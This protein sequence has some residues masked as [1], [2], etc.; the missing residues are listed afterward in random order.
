[1]AAPK[2]NKFWEQRSVH[3]R[4]PIF[5]TPEELW[6]AVCE[7][8]QWV[9]ENPLY[10]RKCFAYQ[11]VVY[12]ED[13]PKMR[14]MTITAMCLALEISHQGWREYCQKKDF[15]EVTERIENII[16]TQKFEGAAADLLNA[17]I[18]ARDLGLK[19]N[20][21]IQHTSPDGSMTPKDINPALVSALVDKLIN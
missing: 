3:G 7:Y 17:N 10:E 5:A 19:D 20:T 14:A 16:R 2:G 15:S 6:D 1:M 13:V 12:T 21:E 18:I 4:N 8:F 11:G 9:D